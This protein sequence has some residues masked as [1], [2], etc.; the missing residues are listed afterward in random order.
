MKIRVFGTLVEIRSLNCE[1][2]EEYRVTPLMKGGEEGEGER[3]KEGKG[4]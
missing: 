2:G 1:G 4:R 3:E